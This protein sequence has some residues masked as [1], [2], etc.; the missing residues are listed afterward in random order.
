ML[1][2]CS[3]ILFLS[4]ISCNLYSEALPES[5]SHKKTYSSNKKQNN[6]Q[7]NI[8]E[9][10]KMI[11]EL[12]KQ[13]QQP[14]KAIKIFQVHLALISILAYLVVLPKQLPS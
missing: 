9:Q 12:Q 2:K 1:R 14:V 11:L 5:T 7:D 13:I 6:D 4:I 10:K 8:S 3:A